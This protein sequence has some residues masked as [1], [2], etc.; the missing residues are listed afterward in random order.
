[1]QT[2]TIPRQKEDNSVHLSYN[3]KHPATFL[4]EWIVGF[5]KETFIKCFGLIC[6]QELGLLWN[7][8]R[9]GV[10][11]LVIRHWWSLLVILHYESISHSVTSDSLQHMDCSL[12]GSSVHGNSPGKNIGMG[13]C[14][15]LQE[16]LPTQGL[17]PVS[18]ITDRFLPSEPPVQTQFFFFFNLDICVGGGI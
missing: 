1:M 10:W 5:W 3:S 12:P 11:Y 2:S 8:Q 6:L 17:N 15:L 9:C 18:F 7:S 14:P 13:S 16:M 4:I